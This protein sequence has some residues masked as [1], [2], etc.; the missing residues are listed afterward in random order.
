MHDEFLSLAKALNIPL[1]SE[2]DIAALNRLQKQW[3]HWSQRERQHAA[4]RVAEEQEAAFATFLDNP[5]GENEQRLLVLA[6]TRLT[7]TR[8]AMLRRAYAALRGRISVQAAEIV[9][10]VLDRVLDELNA[11]HARRREAAEPVMSS[12]DRNPHVIE[13]RVAIDFAGKLSHRA[14]MALS[15]SEGTSPVTLADVLMH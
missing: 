2:D 7:D 10:T 3:D 12:K 13:A 4:A 5:T 15:G 1:L 11:E 9:R 14:Y 8:Y 6:D